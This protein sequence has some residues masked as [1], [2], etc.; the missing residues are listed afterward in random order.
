MIA[1]KPAPS[2]VCADLEILLVEDETI[3]ALM[4]EEL[5][6]GFGCAAVWHASDVAQAM[7]ALDN[8]RP[9]AAVL[10]V[11]L[12]GDFVYPVAERLRSLSVPFVF[13]T[14]YERDAIPPRWRDRPCVQKPIEPEALAEALRVALGR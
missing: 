4:V 1:S 10:D 5:L 6:D 3:V 2:S 7:A 14:G 8:K 11:N 9:A 13:A 12:D